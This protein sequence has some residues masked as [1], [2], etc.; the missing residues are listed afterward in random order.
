MRD[1]EESEAEIMT[2]SELVQLKEVLEG[3]V[4][5]SGGDG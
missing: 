2:D 4:P 1:L 5:E 3:L